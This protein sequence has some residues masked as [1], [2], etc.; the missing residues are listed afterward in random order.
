ME[1]NESKILE[2]LK[3]RFGFDSLRKGQRE[4][5]LDVTSGKDV[6]VIMPTGAGKSLCYQLPAMVLPGTTLVV[7]PLIALMKDQVDGLA[8]KG[9]SAAFINS[10]L[11]KSQTLTVQSIPIFLQWFEMHQ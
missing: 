10:T 3:T 2:V 7:S 6:V 5:I 4:P 8:A 1:E 11:S 9:I